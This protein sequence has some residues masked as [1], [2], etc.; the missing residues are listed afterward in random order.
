MVVRRSAS[1]AYLFRPGWRVWLDA[2]MMLSSRT[3]PASHTTAQLE[4]VGALFLPECSAKAVAVETQEAGIDFSIGDLHDVNPEETVS[5]RWITTG[6]TRMFLGLKCLAS[7]VLLVLANFGECFN[8]LFG[9]CMTKYFLFLALFSIY[10]VN[11]FSAINIQDE[12]L[13]WAAKKC[14][15]TLLI[16]KYQTQRGV[17]SCFD[18]RVKELAS[19]HCGNDRWVIVKS[20]R[21]EQIRIANENRQRYF[22]LATDEV[23]TDASVNNEV[24][25]LREKS[26]ETILGML[27]IHANQC[28]R[29]AS[30]NEIGNNVSRDKIVNDFNACYRNS[31]KVIPLGTCGNI[32]QKQSCQQILNGMIDKYGNDFI[33]EKDTLKNGGKVT[34]STSVFDSGNK[35]D[36]S[37]TNKFHQKRMPSLCNTFSKSRVEKIVNK[38]ISSIFGD[39]DKS[40]IVNGGGNI[41]ELT[42]YCNFFGNGWSLGASIRCTSDEGQVIDG[43]HE[44][45]YALERLSMDGGSMIRKLPDVGDSAYWRI[46]GAGSARTEDNLRAVKGACLFESDFSFSINN[47]DLVRSEFANLAREALENY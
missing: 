14:K 46:T 45:W 29:S 11:A 40:T 6:K 39:F 25:K 16:S 43:L 24:Y 18:H 42:S 20:C 41:K 13:V 22:D 7:L 32:P 28:W 30:K 36:V 33:G 9:V 26:Q 27:I 34:K 17:E 3:L 35:K 31:T 4:V 44:R 5:H 10:S 19:F 23:A 12:Q 38:P 1:H 15:N 37:P 21:D 2:C 8:N 47:D